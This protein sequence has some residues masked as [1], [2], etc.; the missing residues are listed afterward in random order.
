L[1]A[2]LRDALVEAVD[3]AHAELRHLAVAVLHLAHRPFERDDRLLRI[4]DDGG[5]EMRDAVI[6]RELE[7]LGV[8]HDQPA[9]V[10]GVSR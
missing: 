9:L 10:R 1:A 3:V 2:R 7:H 6:D 8:D 5:Q 4:G